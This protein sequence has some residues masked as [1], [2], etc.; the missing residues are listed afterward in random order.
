MLCLDRLFSA[1]AHRGCSDI[2]MCPFEARLQSVADLIHDGLFRYD[3]G[4]CVDQ[5]VCF[6]EHIVKFNLHKRN[7]T[8][9]I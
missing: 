7:V 8:Q 4:M 5:Q 3:D 1:F 2:D 6:Q 9:L